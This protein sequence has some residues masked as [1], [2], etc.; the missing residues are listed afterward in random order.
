M[1]V[2]HYTE[3]I[4]KNAEWEFAG[5]F[6]DDGISVFFEKENINTMDAA[7]Q[8]TVTVDFLTKKRVKNEGMFHI[9]LKIAM[10]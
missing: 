2:A 3:F 5:I 10:R 8:K 7:L 4:K 6:A 1:Q 9:M